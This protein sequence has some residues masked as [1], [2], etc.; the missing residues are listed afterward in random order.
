MNTHKITDRD[1]KKM[2]QLSYDD[3]LKILLEDTT[4]NKVFITVNS[5]L[6]D[7]LSWCYAE[8]GQKNRFKKTWVKPPIYTL[9]EKLAEIWHAFELNLAGEALSE[10]IPILLSK[11]QERALWTKIIQAEYPEGFIQLS[12]IAGLAMQAWRTIHLWGMSDYFD[13]EQSY[14][15]RTEDAKKFIIWGRQFR[16]ELKKNAFIT[17]AERMGYFLN[18]LE[19]LKHAV[20]NQAWIL[21]GFDDLPPVYQKFLACVDHTLLDLKQNKAK[22]YQLSFR[23]A[24]E[25]FEA[26]ASW[27]AALV[28]KGEKN[29]G[30]VHPEL[31]LH[32]NKIEEA[33]LNAFHP[34]H[35][36]C[37]QKII[38]NAFTL[39]AGTPLG[40]QILVKTALR[41]CRLIQSKLS[42]SDIDF[43]LRHGYIGKNGDQV[44]ENLRI[45][46]AL[47]QT[48]K[49]IWPIDVLLKWLALQT[50]SEYIL[51]LFERIKNALN[52]AVFLGQPIGLLSFTEILKKYLVIFDFPGERVLSSL[53]Y[54]IV[55][56][57]YKA[58][59]AFLQVDLILPNKKFTEYLTEFEVFLNFIPFQAESGV[60]PVNIMGVLE[61]SGQL[62]SHL[63][64]MGMNNEYWPG[65]PDPNPFL[66]YDL[67]REKKMPHAS[68]ERE[69]ELSTKI[70]ER[71]K[72]SADRVIFSYSLY[73]EDK[74][75]LASDCI[76]NIP[77]IPIGLI[78]KSRQ[79]AVSP[80]IITEQI[81]DN[82]A[83]KV[84]KNEK[85]SGGT[86]V[87]KS[88]AACPFKGF[89]ES[90]LILKQENN[91]EGV[92][93]ISAMERGI[94]VHDILDKLWA[95]LKT[96]QV[97]CAFS[98]RELNALIEAKIR[99]SI[100]LY[101]ET[102]KNRLGDRFWK[103]EAINLQKVL[104]NWLI[105]EKDREPFEVLL[106]ESWQKIQIE[107]LTLNLCIDRVDVTTS[108]EAV[109]IDYK[110]GEISLASCF[111]D[112]LSEPQL[113]IYC[114]LEKEFL[115]KGVAFGLVKPTGECE[116]I[117]ITYHENVFPGI[118][119]IDYQKNYLAKLG[120]E[121]QSNLEK[122]TLWQSLL[123]Y[124]Q[125]ILGSL[126]KD[127]MQGVALVSPK[128]Y[129]Q[130][131]QYCHLM[132]LCRMNEKVVT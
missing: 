113:P 24:A 132:S 124:W 126:A 74:A 30:I 72:F 116:F 78:E 49:T 105:L 102:D 95:E 4:K 44:S 16:D 35:V 83:P 88:Q 47:K 128:S 41:I 50:E 26:V 12:K 70:T 84:E 45:I 43:I 6:R 19:R 114:L 2:S 31:A 100:E 108:N 89:A 23:T 14:F 73:E 59:N 57:F 39:S 121:C 131:C 66:A 48:N 27:A 9:E 117:G 130:T 18:S 82:I 119:S 94:L 80:K 67:Q 97:L 112:R 76:A 22:A 52:G 25:E 42:F 28:Q 51:S 8:S 11:E 115:P 21:V 122:N 104:M 38:S 101:R 90:R 17:A 40:S 92:L 86:R 63:W 120:V 32:R 1:Y 129:P 85:I 20:N 34:D 118:K 127:F 87:L 61:A 64:V 62:F 29:I 13:D 79:I 111:G 69:Y 125:S 110:T 93:G 99:L 46:Q 96:H 75:C 7:K 60:V 5:R 33:F 37:A 103:N 91:L 123:S 54:Q 106:R 68:A 58:I 71:L 53:E 56:R 15:A 55:D 109:L 107:G 81:E 10:T 65:S 3:L 77:V 98:E 36:Y